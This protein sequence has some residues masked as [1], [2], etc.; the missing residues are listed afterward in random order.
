M[1]QSRASS[2]PE[3]YKYLILL[4]HV[5]VQHAHCLVLVHSESSMPYSEALKALNKHY[6]HSYWFALKEIKDME[7]I[8]PIQD[9]GALDECAIRVQ[10]LAGMLKSLQGKGHEELHCDS[11]VKHVL[12][13]LPKH[14]QER[15][16][17]Q[18]YRTQS[19]TSAK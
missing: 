15:F 9:D 13:R 11:N 8:P 5:K 14:Q 19:S 4:K 2:Q 17:R 12:S 10:S 1:P 16:C 18:Q 7:H 3:R 6:G